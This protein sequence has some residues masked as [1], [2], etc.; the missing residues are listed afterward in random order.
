[1]CENRWRASRY[2]SDRLPPGLGAGAGG[3]GEVVT[4][5]LGF[6]VYDRERKNC[7]NGLAAL[8]RAA[9]VKESRDAG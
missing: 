9:K 7:K 5:S 6:T 4:R 2:K 8:H 3:Q 1:M